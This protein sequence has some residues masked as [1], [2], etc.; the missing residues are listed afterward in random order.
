MSTTE[1][2]LVVRGL[3]KTYGGRKVVAGVSFD[4]R[5]GEIVGLLGK[6]GAGKSTS[7]RMTNGLVHPEAGEVQLAGQDVGRWPLYRRARA[8]MGYLPQDASVFR[9][10]T[11]AKNL[12]AVLEFT[13]RN[14]A[15]RAARRDQ[16]I[17]EFGLG[18]V[19]DSLA[20]HLSGGERRRLEIARCL[21]PR[22]KI[23][24]LDEPFS[25]IDP[26]AVADIQE[27]IQRLKDRGIAILLTDHNVRETL[28]ITD[29]A[30]IIEEG[31]ILASGTPDEILDDPRARAAYLG[32]RF[33][34]DLERERA[35]KQQPG[36]TAPEASPDVREQGQ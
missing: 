33:Y 6:N 9:G 19:R 5:P 13:E 12:M 35:A 3:E 11:V 23:I 2:L 1:P 36:A 14:R 8:G 24:L 25:G 10:L 27:I 29:R 4:V 7:F 15:N 30:Y 28:L 16:L 34:M 20:Q 18:K 31:R 32:E 22:P 17:E 26:I 21:V